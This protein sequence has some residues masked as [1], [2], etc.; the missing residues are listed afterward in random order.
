M[1]WREGRAKHMNYWKFV[2]VSIEWK[3]YLCL[4]LELLLLLNDMLRTS[5]GSQSV[6]LWSAAS[7]SLEL[8]RNAHSFPFPHYEPIESETLGV[9]HSHL[10]FN[11]PSKWLWYVWKFEKPWSRA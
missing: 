2:F 3:R 9:R 5:L 1:R 4:F 7:A 10:N 8:V 6:V 11:K